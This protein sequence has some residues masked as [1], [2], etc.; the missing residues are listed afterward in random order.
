MPQM[1]RSTTITATLAVTAL[2]FRFV[3]NRFG[4]HDGEE[5]R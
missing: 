5:T 1:T 2:T 3:H 4:G